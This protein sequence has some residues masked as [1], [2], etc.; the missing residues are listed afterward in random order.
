MSDYEKKIV[1]KNNII[2]GVTIGSC[3]LLY[4]AYMYFF[5]ASAK[6]G[7]TFLVVIAL[8]GGTIALFLKE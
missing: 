2:D 5:K 3:M 1:R 4:Y 8:T 6:S 7:H